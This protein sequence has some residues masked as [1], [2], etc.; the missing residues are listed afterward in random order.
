MIAQELNADD[1]QQRLMFA[2]TMSN[3]FEENK[4]LKMLLSDEARFHLNGV[5]NKHN[6]HLF[7][8][9]FFLSTKR[10]MFTYSKGVE[11]SNK[12]PNCFFQ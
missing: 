8:Y 5:A 6:C 12:E 7:M 9:N 1:Y 3:M 11:G 2:E 4:E 10:Q